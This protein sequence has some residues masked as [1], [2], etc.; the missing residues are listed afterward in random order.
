MWMARCARI[1]DGSRFNVQ[2]RT[3]E[4]EPGTDKAAQ[5]RNATAAMAAQF[6]DWIRE[7]PDQ[8]MWWQ[9]RSIG[10]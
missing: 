9:R 8:W 10:D 3:I 5:V 1:G 7:D 6:E 2:I 4:A